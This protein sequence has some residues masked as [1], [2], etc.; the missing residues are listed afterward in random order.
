MPFSSSPARRALGLCLA[1]C[2]L[3]AG[4][5]GLAS[6]APS[7]TVAPSDDAYAT[8]KHADKNF[9]ASKYLI[10]RRKPATRSFMRFNLDSAPVSG[11]HATL[12]VYP[13][14]S[15]KKGMRL[16]HAA[17]AGWPQSDLT[18]RSLPTTEKTTVHSGA[19]RA[20]HWK[21]IDVTRL[22]GNSGVV[23]LALATSGRR[24]IVL[25][26]REAGKHAPRLIVRTPAGT[27]NVSPSTQPAPAASPD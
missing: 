18:F 23:S 3:G 10:V 4:V 13:L 5:A 15:S 6:A 14:T 9:G 26:S 17:D 25:A 11:F 16:R 1:L 27:T 2:T 22:V 24:R 12:R 19:L 21:N 20:K 8:A 7:S